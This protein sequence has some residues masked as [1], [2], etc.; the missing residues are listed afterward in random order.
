MKNPICVIAA[1]MLHLSPG[2]ALS[3]TNPPKTD[4]ERIVDERAKTL[5]EQDGASKAR[6]WD[7]DAQG[8]RPWDPGYK[9]P[10]TE[11]PRATK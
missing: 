11:L 3:Q 4:R 1:L 6:M 7:R 9:A 5:R 8:L 2:A 10:E